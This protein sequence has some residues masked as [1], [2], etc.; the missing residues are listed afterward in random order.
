MSNRS[1]KTERAI[2]KALTEAGLSRRDFLRYSGVGAIG[3]SAVMG[4]GALL[5]SGEAQ[6]VTTNARVV[7]VGAGAAGISCA[8]RLNR[9]LRGAD[10]TVIDR[11]EDHQYQPGLTLVATGVWERDK[12]VDRNANFLPSGV[13]WVKAMVKE[14]DPD[15]NRVITDDGQT[16]E[17]DYLMV[18][19]GLQV[20]YDAYE[21]YSR[22]LIGD[23]GIGCVYDNADHAARTWRQIDRFTQSGGKGLFIRPPGAIKCAGAPL[24]VTMLTE[25]RLRRRGTRANTEMHYFAPG[26][27]MFSQP[28]IDEF[29][30]GHF[31]ERDINLHWHHVVKGIDPAAQEVVFDTPD[32]ERTEDYDFIHLVPP[33]SAPDSLRNSALAAGEDS[34]F[35]GWLEVDRYTMQHQRYENVFGAGDINGVPIG[36]TAASVKAQVPVAVNNMV[37]HMQGREMTESYDGYTSCPLITGI[38]KAILVE[39]DYNLDMVPSFPFISPYD[40]HWVPWVMKD[41]LLHGAYNAMMRGRV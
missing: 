13:N 41:R 8:N 12:V 33:M 40:E 18:A 24:K 37:S 26:T 21:G 9:Q 31:P 4:T 16:I 11:R 17:Y 22:E 38:G 35:T 34:N 1:I 20:N 32:G 5:H 6:A 36:K 19:T 23:H 10:I 30:K 15:N 2:H 29:L 39:F 27:G 28:D 7:I 3:A 14:Y 25:D